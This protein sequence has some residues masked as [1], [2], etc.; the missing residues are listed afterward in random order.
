[1]K[2]KMVSKI[3]TIFND[4]LLERLAAICDTNSIENNQHKM[5]LVQ[6]LLWYRNKY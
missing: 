5:D 3:K 4:T 2:V 6:R 1:M